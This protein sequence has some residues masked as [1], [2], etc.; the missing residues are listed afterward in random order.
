MVCSVSW[1]R[2]IGRPLKKQNNNNKSSKDL[3]QDLR[4]A[5]D[6]STVGPSLIRN[7]TDKKPSLRKGNREKRLRC[8]KW[9]KKW[10]ENQWQQVLWRDESSPEPRP[11]HYWSSVGS[12]GQRTELKTA[13]IQRRALE[14][15]SRSLENYSWR[16]LIQTLFLPYIV[17]S[18]LC[19][20]I[21]INL[22]N[23]FPFSWQKR[24][25]LGVA[26]DFCTAQ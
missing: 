15:P 25:E 18:H 11:Q 7:G 24:K 19:R 26:W 23:Y 1:Q 2:R 14:C 4:D 6:P 8:A 12:S 10:T 22:C 20:H 3:T 16:L 9:H 17:F 21:S 5:V 13:N